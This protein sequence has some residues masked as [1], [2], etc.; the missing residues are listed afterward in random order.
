M[1]AREKRALLYALSLVLDCF[2][3][4]GGY[5]VAQEVRDAEWLDAG[6][7]SI[8]VIA[9][10]I[11]LML[12]IAREA[13]S[14]EALASR[15][16]AARRALGALLGAAF[17]IVAISFLMDVEDISRLGFAITFAV[18]AVFIVFDKLIVDFVF[19][20]WMKGSAT[21][22]L[23]ILDGLSARPA[24]HMDMVDVQSMGL[25][26]DLGSP[27]VMDALSRIIAPYD[28]VVV[29]CRYEDRNLW[30]T[31][32][33]GHDV[34]GE[35]LLD[36]DILMGAVAIGQHGELDTLVLSR[37]PL[38]LANRFRKRSLDLIVSVVALLVFFPL[39]ALT[40]LLIRLESPGPVLFRQVRVGQGNRQFTMYKFRSMRADALDADG[41]QSAL[42]ADP[43]VTRVGKFIR[44][45]SIDELPQLF[46]VLLGDMSI[47]G[48]RPH[49]LGSLA[50]D[51]LF[52]EASAHYWVRH[53][54][55]PGITGLAQIRGHRGATDTVD[56]L[57]RRVRADLEYVENWSLAID[58][59]II[60]RTFRVMVHKNAF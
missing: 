28:R 59:L 29:A 58:F 38:N 53:A 55:K 12:S 13:Q 33:K 42:R 43:R 4:I 1:Y 32:L 17:A 50:G 54:L 9:L 11:F 34:G 19:L 25:H 56:D 45:T 51:S 47:V 49:A 40:A 2:A 30:A 21:A 18:A 48:P 44:R 14:A 36:R 5:L 23:L 39:M 16:V 20:R 27:V 7:A 15:T 31:Y 52:W 60:L 35:V 10:P 22:K 8:L 24:K 6:G 37:G 41:K 3:L 57:E 46:N 26:P